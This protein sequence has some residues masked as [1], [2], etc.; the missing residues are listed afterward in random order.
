M[1]V[2]ER[3]ATRTPTPGYVAARLITPSS[4]VVGPSSAE[5]PVPA[6]TVSPDV[7][8]TDVVPST[9]PGATEEVVPTVAVSP[10]RFT[11]VPT[12]T[13]F[14]WHPGSSTPVPGA[15]PTVSGTPTTPGPTPRAP[16]F[17]Y[18]PDGV[19]VV[20]PDRGCFVGAVFGWVRDQN[21]QPLPGVQLRVY[22]PWG[23]V[24]STMT[25]QPPDTGYYDVI[26]G[27]TPATWYVVV[28][29]GLGNQISPV[30]TVEH[31]EGSPGC[32]YETNFRRNPQ[33]R[34]P[35]PLRAQ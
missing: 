6:A 11:A 4:T 9:M 1:R 25:K 22:D 8:A 31:K 29:D 24:F 20:R 16:G 35:V 18:V 23:H 19:P 2:F 34:T 14:G 17:Q 3:L 27:S 21:G 32:W 26:L 13:P 5:T 12:W 28:V 33:W 15:S 7:E 30:V 10:P